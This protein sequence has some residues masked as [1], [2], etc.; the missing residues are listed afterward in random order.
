MKYNPSQQSVFTHLYTRKNF[1]NRDERGFFN[2]CASFTLLT[3]VAGVF[4]ALF[5]TANPSNGGSGQSRTHSNDWHASRTLFGSKSTVGAFARV[6]SQGVFIE[7]RSALQGQSVIR[8]TLE[9]RGARPLG[10]TLWDVDD[11]NAIADGV[12]IDSND[13]WGA[14]TLTGARLSAYPILGNG[15][16]DF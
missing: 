8:L 2:L 13:V 12:S 10:N 1:R 3:L 9:G 6:A 11:D 5:V 7:N 4:L 16:P 15:T 14:W